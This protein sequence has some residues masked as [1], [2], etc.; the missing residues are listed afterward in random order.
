[1]YLARQESLGRYVALKLLRKFENANQS[2]RFLIEGQILAALNHRN[3]ITIYDIG[4][5]D[6]EQPYISMEYLE[7]GDLEA[8][9]ERGVEP[10][11][12][13][14][15]VEAIGDCLSL[16][17]KEGIVHRDIKPA[18]IL[19]HKDGTPILSDFGIA[20][21]E[22]R[23]TRLTMD[24]ST[25][26]SPYYLSP[27]QAECKTLD[28]RADIYGLGIVLYEMLTGKK[29]YKGNSHIET[30]VAHLSDSLPVLPPDLCQYQNLLNK[31]IAKSPDDRFSSA[32]EMVQ[33][34]RQ[35]QGTETDTLSPILDNTFLKLLTS[36]VKVL[37]ASA[38]I[39][40]LLLI[41]T[42][43]LIWIQQPT[44]V[45]PTEQAAELEST[46]S[47]TAVTKE[48][49][50]FPWVT[51]SHDSQQIK[52]FLSKADLALE[53]FRLVLPKNDNAYYYYQ[54]ILDLHPNHESAI[55]GME[56]IA[57]AYADL[58]ESE[59]NRF[60]Y[61]KATRYIR[62]GLRIQPDNSR[63]LELEENTN[64]FEDAPKR[65]LDKIKKIFK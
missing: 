12:A 56:K 60:N 57:D 62:K 16:V 64:V 8:R 7:G 28:G 11:D 29:P 1:M 63:L 10:K 58:A 33:Y 19:F 59:I 2:K 38:G 5:T 49:G 41:I 54:K 9:I 53:E 25:L 45:V 47:D 39:L 26:G 24:G 20:K 4:V 55:N 35:L 36:N 48:P 44:T 46:I 18:N 32:G 65:A 43:T 23:D 51:P 15:V 52:E 40:T 3:I 37:W 6:D 21:Q 14:Q 27:E 30:I 17:H 61:L 34:I 50:L 42:G 22:A 13:L 31:M